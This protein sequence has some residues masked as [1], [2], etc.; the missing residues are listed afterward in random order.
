MSSVKTSEKHIAQGRCVTCIHN[1]ESHLNIAATASDEGAGGG[2]G[3]S[4]VH[5]C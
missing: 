1:E 3:G 4:G 5:H 2:V